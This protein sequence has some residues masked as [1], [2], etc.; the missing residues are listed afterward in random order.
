MVIGL[1]HYGRRY[2]RRISETPG[3][4]FSYEVA[5]YLNALPS[6]TGDGQIPL[7]IAIAGH[8]VSGLICCAL[9]Y[10]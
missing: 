10:C 3:F 8:L 4:I 5:Q 6:A 9:W 2:Q 7:I 1:A